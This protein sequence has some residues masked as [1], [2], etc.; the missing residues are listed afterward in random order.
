MNEGFLD[1]TSSEEEADPRAE[2][3]RPGPRGPRD[4]DLLAIK[5]YVRLLPHST[6]SGETDDENNDEDDENE[7]EEDDVSPSS[8]IICKEAVEFFAVL[9]CGHRAC[10]PCTVKHL[11]K[12]MTCYVCRLP[13]ILPF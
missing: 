11:M 4:P 6:I 12:S 10:P 2:E 13:L 1:W 7:K 5:R 8:C 9:P 3:Y